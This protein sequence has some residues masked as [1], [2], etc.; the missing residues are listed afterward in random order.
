MFIW[1]YYIRLFEKI[2]ASLHH[3][4]NPRPE[5]LAGLAHGV[6]GEVAHHLRDLCHQLGHSVVGGSVHIS[7][8]NAPHVVGLGVTLWLWEGMTTALL[9]IRPSTITVAGNLVTIM[10]GTLLFLLLFI[11]LS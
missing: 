5:P 10:M 2:A 11:F 7:L 1:I 6:P 4:L 3:S 9:L 8:A